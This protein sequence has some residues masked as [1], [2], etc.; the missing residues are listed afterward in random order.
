MAFCDEQFVL[1]HEIAV[2]ESTITNSNIRGSNSHNN[3]QPF[4]AINYII[5]TIGI[6]PSKS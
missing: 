1:G 4:L 2:T 3:M 6:Y 5:V